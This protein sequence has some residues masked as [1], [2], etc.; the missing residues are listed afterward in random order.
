MA[1][2]ERQ[3]ANVSRKRRIYHDA[4]NACEQLDC[5]AYVSR[6][7]TTSPSFFNNYRHC[8]R[9][10]GGSDLQPNQWTEDWAIAAYLADATCVKISPDLSEKWEEDDSLPE[11]RTLGSMIFLPTGQILMLNGANLGVAGYGNV[12][13][14]VGQSYADQPIY[15]P[16]L[17]DPSAP[18]GKRWSREGL[19]ASTVARMYHSTA[20]ILPD[21][22]VFVTGSNP[23]ADYNA[24]SGVKYPT[25]YR[26]ER[27][28]PAYYSQRRPEP[29]GL[30][31]QLGYGGSYFNVTL[32]SDDLS[33]NA[34][35]ISTAKVVI[36][37]PGFSTHALNMGQR[38]I[39]LQS[40]YTG[41]AD[42]TGILHVSQLPPNPAIYPPGPALIF[43]LVNGVPSIGQ[44]IMVGSGKI[45]TQK[46]ADAEVLPESRVASGPEKGSGSSGSGSGGGSKDNGGMKNRQMGCGL[47][48]SLALGISS[49]LL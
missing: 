9:F 40:T 44:Q 33:G 5:N 21:G 7:F 23:N 26:V 17:Y 43:V 31:S 3:S 29:N 25:E 12:S 28:Y 32:S 39:E 24:G 14:A 48:L 18:A 15:K 46:I 1:D 35:M 13:W 19:S 47:L 37:R 8:L 22:S 27:F 36:I 20:T 49:S 38:Y 11:G 16:V 30:L 45:E 6:V 42:N 41:N 10:C 4:F 2:E 34:S